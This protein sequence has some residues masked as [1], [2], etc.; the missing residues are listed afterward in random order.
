MTPQ[1]VVTLLDILRIYANVFIKVAYHIDVSIY[2][3]KEQSI[4][5]NKDGRVALTVE[6]ELLR[7]ICEEND[8]PVTRILVDSILNPLNAFESSPKAMRDFLTRMHSNEVLKH[9]LFSLRDRFTDELS[10]KVFLQIPPR[11]SLQNR[12]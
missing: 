10:T 7:K 9:D 5:E 11:W 2:S 3:L 4:W 1:Q 12:P 8:L 6:L